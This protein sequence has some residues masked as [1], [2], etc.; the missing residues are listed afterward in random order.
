MKLSTR[1]LDDSFPSN[2]QQD[3]AEFINKLL[4]FLSPFFE[5]S[6]PS[7]E[8]NFGYSFKELF[9]CNECK[10]EEREF[11][12]PGYLMIINF[13]VIYYLYF[14]RSKSSFEFFIDSPQGYSKSRYDFKTNVFSF[15]KPDIQ[16]E[17][18]SLNL[19]YKNRIVY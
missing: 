15:V 12:I 8:E 7:L 16:S 5:N 13:K 19:G 11:N 17:V 3:V 10:I 18:K 2:I 6:T 9:K 14:Y 4:N 1:I